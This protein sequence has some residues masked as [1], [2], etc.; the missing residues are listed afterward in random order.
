MSIRQHA[1]QVLKTFA[2]RTVKRHSRAAMTWLHV[3][4]DG[5]TALSPDSY[6][7]AAGHLRAIQYATGLEPNQVCDALRIHG[8]RRRGVIPQSAYG[9]RFRMTKAAALAARAT[10]RK[11]HEAPPTDERIATR[12]TRRV[13]I[14]R[15]PST[16]TNQETTK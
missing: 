7:Q 5:L 11:R 10:G 3:R 2:D 12:P 16:L 15:P 13:A 4:E 9:F 6:E 14:Y 8:W 1:P